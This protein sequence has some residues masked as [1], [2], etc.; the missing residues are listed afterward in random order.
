[1]QIQNTKNYDKVPNLMMMVY[2]QGGVGKT[3]FASTFPKPLLLDFENGAKYFGDRGIEVDVAVFQTWLTIEDKQ[4]LRDALEGYETIIVDPIGEAMDKLIESDTISGAKN[5]QASGDL[6]MA[7]WGAVKKEMR[8]F[9]KWLRYTGK[10]VVLVSH[11]DEKPDD[12][13]IVKRP[14]IATKLS[15][16]LINMV[17]V[18]G[19]MQVISKDGEQ[20]RVIAVDSSDD[21]Y[22]SKDRTGKLGKYV[23]PE[24]DYILGL[25]NDGVKEE[26]PAEEPAEEKDYSTLKLVELQ[27]ELSNRD[28]RFDGNKADL[29]KRLVQ[30]DLKEDNPEK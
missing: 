13:R 11:V 30:D 8:N 19:F 25:L 16:E 27:K 1:M 22:I 7:G 3:T 18:V 15:Q 9:I 28:L 2:G 10:N 23:K 4:Q 21:K 12:E 5:R 17:D 6:T 20:K 24:Y 29:V 14:M 26:K